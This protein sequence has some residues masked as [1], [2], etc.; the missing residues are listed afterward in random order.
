MRISLAMSTYEDPHPKKKT[1]A[2]TSD[3]PAEEFIEQ[4]NVPS[5]VEES[6][7]DVPSSAEEKTP[8]EE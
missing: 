3:A 6:A 1:T 8:R 7:A 5:K 4:E 2:A